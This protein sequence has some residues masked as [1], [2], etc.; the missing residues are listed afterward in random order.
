MRRA[1]YDLE[2]AEYA[3]LEE[4]KDDES[5]LPDVEREQ[6]ASAVA[7]WLIQSTYAALAKTSPDTAQ[8]DIAALVAQNILIPND[9]RVRRTSYRLGDAYDPHIR[10]GVEPPRVID[11]YTRGR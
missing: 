6:A 3:D 2:P 4:V 7:A 5:A 9:S 8:R 11:R 10:R 1:K